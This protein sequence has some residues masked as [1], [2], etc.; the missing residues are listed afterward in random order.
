MTME[1]TRCI[2][3]EDIES[4]DKEVMTLK[5]NHVFHTRC[6][7]DWI[8]EHGSCPYCRKHD[9]F[10]RVKQTVASNTIKYSIETYIMWMHLIFIAHIISVVSLILDFFISIESEFSLFVRYAFFWPSVYFSLALGSFCYIV[11]ANEI[12]KYTTD[13][14]HACHNYLSNLKTWLFFTTGIL[15][16]LSHTWVSHLAFV[17]ILIH[18]AYLMCRTNVFNRIV[19]TTTTYTEWIAQ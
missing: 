7:G 18:D 1:T 11:L 8:I 13:R 19:H 9:G 12:H 2:C 15:L 17:F 10:E 3:L 6:I 4:G 14:Y 5:C 16:C